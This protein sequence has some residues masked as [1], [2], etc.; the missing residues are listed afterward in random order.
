M[1]EKPLPRP[2]QSVDPTMLRV[3]NEAMKERGVNV[4]DYDLYFYETDESIIISA[5]YKGKPRTMRG[6]MPGFPDYEVEIRRRDASL[7]S[8]RVPR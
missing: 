1:N 6:S 8:V 7:E 4:A 3:F 5:A 2:V